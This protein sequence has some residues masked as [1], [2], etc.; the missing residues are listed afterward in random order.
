MCADVQTIG[1][2]FRKWEEQMKIIK[3]IP[4]P[5]SAAQ[6]KACA[7]AF[8]AL[9]KPYLRGSWRADMAFNKNN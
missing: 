8:T 9:G 7:P 2:D 4:P 1:K 5:K 6:H 3:L